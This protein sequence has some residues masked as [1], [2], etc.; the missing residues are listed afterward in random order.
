MYAQ[1]EQ[2]HIAAWPSFPLYRGGAHAL[3]AE[4]NNAASRVH[5]VEGSCF[6][7]APCATVSPEMVRVLCGEVPMERQRLLAGDGLAA[8]YAP[9]GQLM[10]A[11]LPENQE[12]LVHADL[13]LSMIS[14]AKAAADP[15]GHY[16]RPDVT[17]LWL[18]KTPGD[19][20]MSPAGPAPAL[21]APVP[22]APELQD[23]PA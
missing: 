8:I 19:R 5:A 18:N 4:V 11:P 12:G 9:D 17:R 3:G 13:D 14:L 21:K 1:N 20:V 22:A 16:A 6:V 2:V 15:A 23:S 7:V 10:H